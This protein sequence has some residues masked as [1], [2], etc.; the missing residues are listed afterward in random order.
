MTQIQTQ[1]PDLLSDTTK[2]A[3]EISRVDNEIEAIKNSVKGNN[4]D[5]PTLQGAE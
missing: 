1:R 3:S 5:V 2:A 4:V